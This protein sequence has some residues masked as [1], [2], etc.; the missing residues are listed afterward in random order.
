M[1]VGI[2]LPQIL[3]LSDAFGEADSTSWTDEAAEVTAH[4]LSADDMRFTRGS[5]EGNR[6]MS[7]I[8]ARQLT[9]ATAY[10]PLTV[11]LG[12]DERGAVK[13]TRFGE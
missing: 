6:L 7:A 1:A 12:I 9:T 5:V 8:A 4:T 13:I 3:S 11:D 2:F 10:T